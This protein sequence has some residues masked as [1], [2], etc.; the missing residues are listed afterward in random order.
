M[1]RPLAFALFAVGTASLALAQ[2][3]KPGTVFTGHTEPVYAVAISP[4]GKLVATGSFDKSVK[5]WDPA[6]GKE[7]KALAKDGHTSQVLAVAFSPDG[8]LIASGGSDNQAKL[9]KHATA[10][11]PKALAHPNLVDAVAFD[12]SGKFLATGCHDG[13]VRIWDIATAKAEKTIAAHL[14]PQPQP[15]YA[16]AWSPDGKQIASASFDKSIKIWDATT[17]KIVVEIKG[18]ID[19]IPPDTTKTKFAGT[20]IGS[21][22]DGVLNAPPDS[23]HRD[24][25]FTLAFSKDGKQLAS[26]SS[27]RT[28]KLW[29]AQTGQLV[30]DFPNPTLKPVP[31]GTPAPS[32][33]GFIHQVKWTADGTKLVSAGTAPRGQGYLAV[34]T[35]ADGRLLSGQELPVGPIYGLELTADGNAILACGSK[36]RGKSESDAVVVALPGK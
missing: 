8:T 13:N 5:L 28:L 23:G 24:Q 25:V 29:N 11:A 19:R 6:T 7:L 12:K 36:V 33:P 22:G 3:S 10:E 31:P 16:V 30:R 35:V 17:A 18:G 21:P 1:L 14:L 2:S 15:I 4:D 9:W 34:W 26:A 32:H 27:D 20:L